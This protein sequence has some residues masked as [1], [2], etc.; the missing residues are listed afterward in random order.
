M[1]I[2]DNSVSDLPGAGDAGAHP[3]SPRAPVA[4]KPQVPTHTGA[5]K[6]QGRGKTRVRTS[7]CN[8][9]AYA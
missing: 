2:L 6:Q 9:M 8:L 3:G 7:L 5:A 4:S 1:R